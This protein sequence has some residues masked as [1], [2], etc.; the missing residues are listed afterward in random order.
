MLPGIT[1]I[2]HK[3]LSRIGKLP[4]KSQNDPFP[5]GLSLSNAH[6]EAA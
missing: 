4:P 6:P 2:W 5:G 1:T 3:Y